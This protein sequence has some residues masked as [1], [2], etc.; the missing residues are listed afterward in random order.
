[1][2][3]PCL[4]HEILHTLSREL[5]HDPQWLKMMN[6]VSTTTHK[7]LQEIIQ[8]EF[9]SLNILKFSYT[10]EWEM[11]AGAEWLKKSRTRISLLVD[12]MQCESFRPFETCLNINRGLMRAKCLL[13]QG[14]MLAFFLSHFVPARWV[15]AAVEE[16]ENSQVEMLE[17]SFIR[18]P[19]S[20]MQSKWPDK[21][22]FFSFLLLNIITSAEQPTC[23]C[24][25]RSRNASKCIS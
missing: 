16:R 21:M 25:H 7:V 1:M 23:R 15:Q 12:C 9:S 6:E 17:N 8:L 10:L 18:F 19:C 3:S 11:L 2:L 5:S 14:I 20:F 13:I 22:G 4:R 24:V